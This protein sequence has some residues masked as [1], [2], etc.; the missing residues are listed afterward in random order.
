MRS[1]FKFSNL[2]GQVY[3]RGNIVFTEDGTK[4]ISPVGN[5]VNV[6]DLVN[7]KSFTFEYEHRKP[8]NCL[9]ISDNGNLMLSV[10]VDGRAILVNF[11]TKHE[12]HHF[13]FKEKIHK[14]KFS[15]CGK[16]FAICAGRFLQIWRISFNTDNDNDDEL[17]SGDGIKE[18][19]PFVKYRI[20][21]GHSQDLINLQWS[22]D[23]RFILS[24]SK[25]LTTKIWSLSKEEQELAS[26]TFSGHKDYVMGAFFSEDQEKIYTIS[27]DGA[28][29]QWEFTKNSNLNDIDDENEEE[30]EEEDVD[31]TKYS[32]RIT[33]KKYFY[34]RPA[35]VS[36]VTFHTE[37]NMLLVGFT[38]GEFR[39]YEMPSF[40]LIQKLSM[41]SNPISTVSI[42]KTGEWLALGSKKLG[43]L[44][45]YEWQSE[46]Y[47]LKQQGH[48]DIMNS[49]CY[50][51]DGSKL[52]TASDDGKIKVWD[53]NSGFCLATFNEHQSSVTQI[54]FAQRGQVLYSASLDGTVKAWDLL[55]YRNFRTFTSTERLSFQCLAVD[56]SGEIVCAGSQDSFEIFVW[57][58][59]TGQLL[60]TL[61]GHT[62]P[63]SHLQFSKENGVLASA[64]W[65]KTIRIWN[66]FSR[67]QDVEPIEVF[68]DVTSLTI[69]YDGKN[70]ACST[71]QGQILIFDIEDAKQIGNIDGKKDI[72]VGRHI[73]DRFESKNSDRGRFFKTINYSFDGEGIVAAGDNNSIC[74]YDVKNEVLLKK[75]TV[76]NNMLLDGTQELLN[77]SRMT[78]FGSLDLVEGANSI[79]GDE[80]DPVIKNTIP[81]SQRGGDMSSRSL[82]QEIRVTSVQFSPT[83][84]QFACTSTTGLL[85]YSIDDTSIFDPFDLD[86]DITPMSIKEAI[87]EKEYL[88]AFIM[89]FRLNDFH[90]INEVYE[91]IPI[92]EIAI[93]SKN[94]PVAYLNRILKFVGEYSLDSAHLEFNLIWIKSILSYHGKYIMNN[95]FKYASELRR[96][97]KFLVRLGKETTQLS[98]ENTFS[99]MVLKSIDVAN[100]E[101]GEMSGEELMD[102]AGSEEELNSED[103]DVSMNEDESDGEWEGFAEKVQKLPIEEESDEDILL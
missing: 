77:S 74:L 27:R 13:N 51:P 37:T 103:E 87:V 90:L 65:D 71:I 101:G 35:L 96:I 76:S 21:A 38:S 81:G 59:Q 79:E 46:S 56:P 23:S 83:A 11:K 12:L 6:Y 18:F 57:N 8:I 44:I 26:M 78:E 2:L 1:G 15:P 17:D 39:I 58:V 34:N 66:I 24:T 102:V 54:Q 93:I 89:S 69:R 86:F 75:F 94:I 32:W 28:L 4:L 92:K 25:D 98:K 30:E 7:S 14:V 84:T 82:K 43:Q 5:R 52:V 100:K 19:Q 97:Q 73:N 49:L 20:H 88:E 41:G 22:K 50:S 48:F 9:D 64:S 42:N 3:N 99:Y 80:D 91:S 47:I 31:F 85:I 55:R 10:D 36:T 72:D 60:D 40:N 53:V 62:G 70:V 61:S 63:I 29:F 16:F 68:S 95:K 33:D 67:S 45:V